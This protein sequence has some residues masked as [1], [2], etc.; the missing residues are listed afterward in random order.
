MFGWLFVSIIANE[1]GP[2]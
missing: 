1:E 2:K